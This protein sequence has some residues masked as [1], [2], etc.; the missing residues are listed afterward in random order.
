M[1]LLHVYDMTGRWPVWS[2]YKQPVS[3][4]HAAYT[5]LFLVVLSLMF[6]GTYI[7]FEGRVGCWEVVAKI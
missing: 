5:Y 1:Y 2:V 6:S 4:T 7:M 3:V